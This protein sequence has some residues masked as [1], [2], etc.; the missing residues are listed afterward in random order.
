MRAKCMT[1]KKKSARERKR[2]ERGTNRAA[3]YLS[4]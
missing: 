1:P 3:D 2:E 4:R